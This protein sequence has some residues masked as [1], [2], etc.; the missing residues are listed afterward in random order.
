M[1]TTKTYRS[2]ILAGNMES[3]TTGGLNEHGLSIAI[4]FL[5]MRAGLAC[6]KGVVGPNSN[7]WTTS[8]IANGLLRGE[9]AREA[10]RVIGAMIDEYGFLYYRASDAGVAL[11]IADERETWLLEI[12]GPGADWTAGS[13]KPGGVWC[14]QRIP[15]GEVGC[16][17]N[18][19]RIGGV[20]LEDSDHFLA[21][22]NIFS[23][24]Q[25][26]GLWKPEEPFVWYEVYGDPGSSRI[27]C[28]NGEPS[29]WLLLP[30]HSR[31]RAIPPWTDIRFR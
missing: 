7:H 4:E 1:P 25:D 9:T 29:A 21:S 15:D 31:Q 24:A 27:P 11:P 14:A 30:W 5:P 2:L 6:D 3:M 10:I 16:S 12:F 18:R 28:A 17:A 19:S 23:L 20:N 13:G 26:L 22:A 8:L